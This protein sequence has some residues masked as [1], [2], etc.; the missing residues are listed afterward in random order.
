[1]Q[2]RKHSAYETLVNIV[3][4]YSINSV[5]TAMVFPT[6]AWSANLRA[7][8]IFTVV[9]IV[10]SYGLRRAFNAWHIRQVRAAGAFGLWRAK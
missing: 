3:V 9:S 8:V 1:M 5:V 6:V 10:R 4:G 2:S 7:G